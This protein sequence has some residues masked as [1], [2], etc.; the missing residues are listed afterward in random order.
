MKLY[1]PILV[2]TRPLNQL[3]DIKNLNEFQRFIGGS[4][5]DDDIDNE[6]EKINKGQEY[7]SIGSNRMQLNALE[8]FL[9]ERVHGMT[10]TVKSKIEEAAGETIDGYVDVATASTDMDDYYYERKDENREIQNGL[11]VFPDYVP[12]NLFQIIID[13]MIQKAG[14]PENTSLRVVKVIKK[15]SQTNESVKETQVSKLNESI[16]GGGLIIKASS[17]D[18]TFDF[19]YIKSFNAAKQVMQYEI[20]KIG[21]KIISQDDNDISIETEDGYITGMCVFPVDNEKQYILI[22]FNEETGEF[23]IDSYVNLNLAKRTMESDWERE[24]N[25]EGTCNQQ[26]ALIP[27]KFIYEIIINE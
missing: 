8:Q 11:V 27:G 3:K 4:D 17:E 18:E 22:K 9:K 21:G 1:K 5:F 24:G 15:G 6:L 20:E 7:D 13:T 25:G 26:Q 12:K 14:A 2:S 23:T 16:T 19:S 10:F